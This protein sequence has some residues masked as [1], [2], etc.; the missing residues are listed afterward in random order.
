MN[1]KVLTPEQDQELKEAMGIQTESTND[2]VK[3]EQENE[4]SMLPKSTP[5]KEQT[6][7]AV[8]TP[9]TAS[10]ESNVQFKRTSS[11]QRKALLDGYKELFM[12]TP[13]ITD[14]QPVFIGRATRDK[15]D[16]IVRRLG[17]RKMS[18]SGFLEN[19]AKH[20]LDAYAEELEQWKRL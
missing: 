3:P 4:Q 18:V 13:K 7:F 10:S 15:I 2:F 19:L 9:Q 6:E 8:P 14:R 16:E 17:E 11:K 12:R 1:Q 20:H 5:N